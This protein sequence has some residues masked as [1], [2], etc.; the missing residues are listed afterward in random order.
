L[1]EPIFRCSQSEDEIHQEQHDLL[2]VLAA[3]TD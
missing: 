1:D 2:P 3:A